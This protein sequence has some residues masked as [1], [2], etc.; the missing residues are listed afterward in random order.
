[1]IQ[2]IAFTVYPVRDINMSRRFYEEKLGLKLSRNFR[3]E[4]VE[5]DLGDSTFA[6][7]TTDMGHPPGAKGAVVAFEVDDFDATI[8]ALKARAVPFV[9][10][11]FAT[12]VCRMAVVADPDGNHVTIHRRNSA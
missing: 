4:W 8:T 3:D 1:M 9:V 12:P 2:S 5:Y 11:P 10:E 6:V 7:T